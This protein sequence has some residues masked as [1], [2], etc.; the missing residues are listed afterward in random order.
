MLTN[1]IL[2]DTHV[3]IWAVNGT[4]RG[5]AAKEI[6]AAAARNE[7]LLSPVTAWEIGLLSKRGR[8]PVARDV[9]AYVHAMFYRSGVVVAP[10]TPAIALASTILPDS[11]QGDAADRLLIA[12]AAALDVHLMTRDPVILE[13]A[14]RTKHVRCLRC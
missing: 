8:L 5:A 12:T 1:P 4:L 13:Y 2:L 6:D 3:A 10:F 9:E 7:L 11:I 14:A